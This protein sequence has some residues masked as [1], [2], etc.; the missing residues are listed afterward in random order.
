MNDIY[1]DNSR[2]EYYSGI[3]S[4]IHAIGFVEYIITMSVKYYNFAIIQL[5]I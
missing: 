5:V 2:N 4:T 1:I 3:V